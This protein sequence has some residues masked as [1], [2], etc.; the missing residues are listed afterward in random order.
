MHWA[1]HGVSTTSGVVA[2]CH[3]CHPLTSPRSPLDVF[4]ASTK[5]GTDG[6]CRLRWEALF[7]VLAALHV[8]MYDCMYAMFASRERQRHTW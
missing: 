1:N 7:V 3:S 5:V 4:G 2:E 6:V 8:C